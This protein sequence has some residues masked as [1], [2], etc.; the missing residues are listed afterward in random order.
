ML[1]G[2]PLEDVTQQMLGLDRPFTWLFVR[3]VVKELDEKTHHLNTRIKRRAL[4]ALRRLEQET[5]LVEFFVPTIPIQ[6][7]KEGFDP[8]NKDDVIRAELVAFGNERPDADVVLVTLDI[9]MRIMA[10]QRGITVAVPPVD[11][12]AA[13]EVDETERENR[14]LRTRIAELE[15]ARPKLNLAFSGGVREIERQVYP[16]LSPAAVER[17]VAVVGKPEPDI[18]ISTFLGNM[19]HDDPH[20]DE[21]LASYVEKVRQ[22]L[23]DLWQR[24]GAL[25]HLAFELTN[26]ADVEATNVLVD[27]KLPSFARSPKERPEKLTLPRKPSRKVLAG[28]PNALWRAA[29]SPAPLWNAFTLP[30]VTAPQITSWGPSFRVP[31][32]VAYREHTVRQRRSV[33]LAPVTLEIH[34]IPPKFSIGYDIRASNGTGVK[35]GSLLVHLRQTSLDEAIGTVLTELRADEA[36]DDLF[37]NETDG[38]EGRQ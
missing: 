24:R 25:V 30:R 18:D 38:K 2:K 13:E 5:P 26:D 17:I 23:P 34:R 37:P 11:I 7:A 35:T 4:T 27:L 10:R 32:V 31:G 6:Y 14:Q 29:V 8:D 9:G 1:H 22:T 20:Y 3:T 21:K 36:V 19:W 33:A 12:R 16:S 28:N 15:N